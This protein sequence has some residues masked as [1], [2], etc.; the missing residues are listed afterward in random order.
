M[1]KMV[2]DNILVLPDKDTGEERMT[3]GGIIMPSL[4]KNPGEV[5]LNVTGK[6]IAVGPGAYYFGQW[7]EP[8]VKV[9]DH[10]QYRPN[11]G[12][13]LEYDMVEYVSLKEADI[14]AVLP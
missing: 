1:I 12:Y 7:I 4:P 14:L 10:I 13:A 9:G 6:V 3:A 8:T 11:T 5:P 2:L